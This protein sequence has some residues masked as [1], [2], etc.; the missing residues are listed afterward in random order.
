MLLL[1][2]FEMTLPTRGKVVS[3]AI[4]TFLKCDFSYSVSKEN[5]SFYLF[6]DNRLNLAVEFKTSQKH[7][8]LS[9]TRFG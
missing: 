7:E 4:V 2:L 8:T 6:I 3:R 9:V 1:G 5:M